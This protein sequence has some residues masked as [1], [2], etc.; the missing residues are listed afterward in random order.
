ML[1]V[2]L[3]H[4]SL[5]LNAWFNLDDINHLI[6]PRLNTP[7]CINECTDFKVSEGKFVSSRIAENVVV[8]YESSKLHFFLHDTK[9]IRNCL[10]DGNVRYE[11]KKEIVSSLITWLN[12]TNYTYKHSIIDDEDR[13]VFSEVIEELIEADTLH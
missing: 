8:A 2:L 3:M 5:Q 1:F 7:Q 11:D 6:E 13:S 10:W 12:E 4:L 9:R